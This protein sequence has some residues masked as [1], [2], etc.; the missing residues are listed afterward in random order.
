MVEVHSGGVRR[1][2]IRCTTP[3]RWA[4]SRSVTVELR[5]RVC[6][7]T[8]TLG[9]RGTKRS[10]GTRESCFLFVVS[11]TDIALLC[12]LPCYETDDRYV[13]RTECIVMF[14]QPASRSSRSTVT[15]CDTYYRDRISNM[16]PLVPI[17]VH[18]RP[19]AFVW[20]HLTS[21]LWGTGGA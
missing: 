21:H 11:T 7:T 16:A 3:P 6:L 4:C 10:V 2:I 14:P 8:G 17:Q 15:L 5:G 18:L 9:I 19:I 13:L 12:Y 1:V 20:S